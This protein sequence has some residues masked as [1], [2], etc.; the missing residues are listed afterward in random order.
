MNRSY[1]FWLAT[2]FG[3]LIG[4]Y[5]YFKYIDKKEHFV[6]TENIDTKAVESAS[7][8]SQND[9][10]PFVLGTD[11]PSGNFIEDISVI[12]YNTKMKLYLSSF[13]TGVI[14][15]SSS[16]YCSNLMRWFD[17]K[18]PSVYFNV[19]TGAPPSSIVGKGLSMKNVILL[20]PPCDYLANASNPFELSPFTL[21]LYAS[22]NAPDFTN[23]NTKEITIFRIY[24]ETP[25]SVRLTMKPSQMTGRTAVEL[26]L[27]AEKNRYIWDITTSTLL[28]NGNPTLYALTVDT[29]PASKDKTAIL[30][31]G[32][33]KYT[34]D[35]TVSQPIKLG[36][37]RMEINSFGSLDA[38]LFSFGFIDQKLTETEID[39]LSDYMQ[40]QQ[41]GVER[42]VIETANQ[43]DNE[44]KTKI[45]S[46]KKELTECKYKEPETASTNEIAHDGKR[47]WMIDN[48]EDGY[49]I[50]SESKSEK[51]ESFVVEKKSVPV[52]AIMHKN[53]NYNISYPEDIADNTEGVSSIK[54]MKQTV[55]ENT[56]VPVIKKYSPPVES[57]NPLPKSIDKS[58]TSANII[59]SPPQGIDP[60][61]YID[62]TDTNDTGVPRGINASKL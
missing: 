44:S 13:S 33:S 57:S 1:I 42:R 61:Y 2:A 54:P 14:G 26:V 21:F 5:L 60:P 53:N 16:P 8:T 22:M 51:K 41:T 4:I 27:G 18:D 7:N 11:C 35:I 23:T 29:N 56:T 62:D 12:P 40:K 39:T 58:K 45:N 15:K 50:E 17:L 10:K 28:S 32:K 59:S 46:L 30:Y 52:A 34:A 47:R 37:S 48:P 49:E 19:N 38:V 9:K 3:V 55:L 31:I 6:D 20:G 24:A 36:N 25:N 43:K